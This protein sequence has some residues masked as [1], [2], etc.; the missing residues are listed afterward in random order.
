M[1]PN[2]FQTLFGL[3]LGLA[4]LA[5]VLFA[6][7]VQSKANKAQAGASS[8]PKTETKASA[9]L[10]QV[11]ARLGSEQKTEAEEALMKSSIFPL[12]TASTSVVW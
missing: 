12:M 1:K 11:F 10:D 8:V 9:A 7:S 4:L 6:A 2:R 5:V 3:A